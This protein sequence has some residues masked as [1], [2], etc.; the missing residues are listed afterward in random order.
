MKLFIYNIC[1][2]L[3]YYISIFFKNKIRKY[4]QNTDRN[5]VVKPVGADH[6]RVGRNRTNSFLVMSKNDQFISIVS[7]KHG[8]FLYEHGRY[9]FSSGR[10]LL[11]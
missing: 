3:K 1:T 10:Y 4:V 2:R 6:D 5:A 7:V 11:P 9:Y 8:H